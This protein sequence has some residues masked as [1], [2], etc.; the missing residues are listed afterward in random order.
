MIDFTLALSYQALKRRFV[1]VWAIQVIHYCIQYIHQRGVLR[2][3][4]GPSQSPPPQPG[5]G[6]G[7]DMH[8]CFV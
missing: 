8:I 6:N 4:F 1:V 5:L 3:F 7:M 2:A